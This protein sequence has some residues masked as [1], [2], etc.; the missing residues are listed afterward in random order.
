MALIPLIDC[1]ELLDID[2]KTLRTSLKRARITLTPHPTDA[3]IKC[4]TT[5]QIE[6]LAAM[7]S[8]LLRPRVDVLTCASEGGHAQ[9]AS[10]NADAPPDPSVDASPPASQEDVSL[11][12]KLSLLET[13]VIQLSDHLTGL[14]LVLLQQRDHSIERRISSLETVMRELVGRPISLPLPPDQQ[15][16]VENGESVVKPKPVRQL[17]PAEERARSRMPPLIEYS[18]QGTYVIVSSQEGELSLVPD[19]REWFDWLASLSSFR[20]VGKLGRFTAYR[21]SKHGRP[22]RSWRAHRRIHQHNYKHSLGVDSPPDA[23]LSR[24]SGCQ[25][26]SSR[27]RA[28]IC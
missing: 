19:S 25:T 3:R 23:C 5:Q 6:L 14:A 24:A 17:N 4:L 13:R 28:L 15:A 27:G 2:P 20:F 22:S 21:D 8:R 11:L 9:G 18:P 12:Q 7:H 1:Y 10:W 16:P 26:P